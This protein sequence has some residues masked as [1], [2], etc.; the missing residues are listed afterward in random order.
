MHIVAHVF[1]LW[2]NL[3]ERKGIGHRSETKRGKGR[4][5]ERTKM[6]S[7]QQRAERLAK[8]DRAILQQQRQQQEDDGLG[9]ASAA[10]N[11][12]VQGD[13]LVNDNNSGSTL[14]HTSA[15]SRSKDAT[16]KKSSGASAGLRKRLEMM[17]MPLE[18]GMQP[19]A[20]V[21]K[22]SPNTT[23]TASK[24]RQK[25]RGTPIADPNEYYERKYP[26][27]HEVAVGDDADDSSP[28]VVRVHPTPQATVHAGQEVD[29]W[30]QGTWQQQQAAPSSASQPPQSAD[31]PAGPPSYAAGPGNV[32]KTD[33]VFERPTTHLPPLRKV[34]SSASSKDKTSDVTIDEE[35][36]NKPKASRFKQRNENKIPT[37]ATAGGFPSMDMPLG[38]LSRRGIKPSTPKT[39][40]TDS[41]QNASE[42]YNN[43]SE[44]QK[45][46]A[47]S[48]EAMLGELSRDQ[49]Q[50]E[51]H[52]LESK[53]SPEL[54]AFMRKRGKLR[55]QN[56]TQQQSK[57]HQKK[58]TYGEHS[59]SS[60]EEPPSADGASKDKET[61]NQTAVDSNETELDRASFDKLL[62]SIETPEELQEAFNKY[63][64]AS[65]KE[66]LKQMTGDNIAAAASKTPKKKN[67][68]P[69][70]PQQTDLDTAT[71]LLRSSSSK[72]Q[73]LGA[74]TVQK[75]LEH[76]VM[77]AEAIPPHSLDVPDI[78]SSS[79]HPSSTLVFSPVLPV[80]LRCLLD[81]PNPRRN[82]F[83]HNYVLRSMYAL[84]TLVS[85]PS[86]KVQIGVGSLSRSMTKSQGVGAGNEIHQQW[87]M[88]DAVPTPNVEE[89]YSVQPTTPA[90]A[91]EQVNGAGPCYVTGASSK[92]AL[93]DGKAFMKDPLWTLLSKMRIIPCLSTLLRARLKSASLP[94]PPSSSSADN[95]NTTLSAE[96][97]GQVMTP[98]C[99]ASI[100]GI[101]S[102][103]S[104][105]LAGAARAIV[106]QQDIVPLLM[107]YALTPLTTSDLETN[108]AGDD[109][110]KSEKEQVS[111]GDSGKDDNLFVVD[112]R[113]AKPCLIL[114]CTLA[115][116]SRYVASSNVFAESIAFLQAILGVTA[117]SHDEVEVQRRCLIL[118]RTLLR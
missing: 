70:H 101:L 111:S 55:Q 44:E 89:L 75:I 61:T 45:S 74:K 79:K 15:V 90:A 10:K 67:D 25:K 86:H 9:V 35:V 113:F 53:L 98:E 78:S 5:S 71:A 84:T 105:R 38:S 51:V 48:S 115:R 1:T 102:M 81:A 93:S 96:E 114:L 37:P 64:P 28:Y 16:A 23:N 24:A 36:P 46:I 4:R 13:N 6:N 62:S 104:T 99:F 83:L 117:Q 103:M 68:V 109:E 22:K 29:P 112:V 20:R 58:T 19:S 26:E 92:S 47:Q 106:D 18:E 52:E 82:I 40:P 8:R 11:A 34:S 54:I 118:W 95:S 77:E 56:Q 73:L 31:P 69:I 27:E 42:K 49:I 33:S 76:Q 57:A 12:S 88:D 21:I 110:T 32:L 3:L 66:K 43:M 91:G 2:K 72:Q 17:E 7:R 41:K 100:C 14:T 30:E 85:H 97:Q 116:Q 107:E 80:A 63:Q 59:V 39:N 108:N 94:V 87:F 65:E 50:E 60:T